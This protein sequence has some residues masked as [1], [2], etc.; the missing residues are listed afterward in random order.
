MLEPLA[1]LGR[2][3]AAD[4]D[5]AVLDQP[6]HGG[7]RQARY[8]RCDHRIEATADLGRGDG[9]LVVTARGRRGDE[10]VVIRQEFI[11]DV[12]GDLVDSVE[13]V[14]AGHQILD[15]TWPFDFTSTSTIAR[16]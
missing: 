5:L 1:G 11:G 12:S 13:V 16:S 6:L 15:L 3:R 4:P 10:L 14:G 7:A 9:D 2:D 8:P